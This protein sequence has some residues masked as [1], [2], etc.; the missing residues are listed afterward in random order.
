[1]GCRGHKVISHY[2]KLTV[3]VFCYYCVITGLAT[4]QLVMIQK[5]VTPSSLR[6]SKNVSKSHLDCKPIFIFLNMS[7]KNKKN[8]T[9]L[10]TFKLL[11]CWRA[12]DVVV[13]MCSL[14]L[15]KRQPT[16]RATDPAGVKDSQSVSLHWCCFDSRTS[17]IGRIP[18]MLGENRYM[19]LAN[20]QSSNA[21][22]IWSFW[23]P[24]TPQRELFLFFLIWHE[25]KCINRQ[26]EH[27]M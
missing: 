10:N 23:F 3:I 15:K 8:D 4:S 18:V 7:S 27:V 25:L 2:Y 12:N 9:K 6:P 14:Y 22:F 11:W 26:K 21:P 5:P 17:L 19:P 1:M 16:S 24:S 20:W 13:Q